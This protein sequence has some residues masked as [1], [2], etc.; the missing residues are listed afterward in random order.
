MADYVI[1]G[2]VK[3]KNGNPIGN[4]KVQAMDSDQE[5][6]EDRNDDML[7]SVWVKP[8][9][10]FEIPF[11]KDQFKE[12]WLEGNPDIYLIIRNP[13]GEQ[14]NT[15]EIR[16]GV[17]ASNTRG[18]TFDI[19]LGS[20]EKSAEPPVD[21]YSQNNQRVL[22]AFARIGDTVDVGVGDTARTFRLLTSAV[23]AWNLY[24]REDMWRVIQY[25]GP[26]VPKYP[27]KSKH[28]HELGWERKR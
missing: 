6:F 9:G 2:S 8:D 26:Q 14:I 22:A 20:L 25:D 27:W 3:D 16:R 19:V 15:T 18:L 10:T 17:E 11:D 23:N 12:G 28:E 13:S 7:G 5:W 21:P 24:T 4:V 1:R